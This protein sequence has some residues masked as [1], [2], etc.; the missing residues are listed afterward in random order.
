MIPKAQ[1]HCVPLVKYLVE[2]TRKDTEKKN[3]YCKSVE[4]VLYETLLT[5]NPNLFANNTSFFH[6]T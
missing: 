4:R 3:L 1:R 5:V 2:V 6:S